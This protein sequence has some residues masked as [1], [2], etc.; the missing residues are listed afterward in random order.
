VGSL[1]IGLMAMQEQPELP[2]RTQQRIRRLVRK[3]A[4]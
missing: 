3:L 2:D 4:R 1:F